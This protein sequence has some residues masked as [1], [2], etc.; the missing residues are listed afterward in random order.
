MMNDRITEHE[1]WKDGINVFRDKVN[2]EITEIYQ[3]I[4]RI[5]TQ[6]LQLIKKETT[7]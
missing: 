3:S 4:S 6:I 1:D 5:E 2:K 7:P